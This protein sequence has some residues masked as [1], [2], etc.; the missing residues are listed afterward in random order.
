MSVMSEDLKTRIEARISY[1]MS[2]LQDLPEEYSQT[3]YDRMKWIQA[4]IA[5]IHDIKAKFLQEPR[6]LS[7]EQK[8]FAEMLYWWPCAGDF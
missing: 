4:T 1:W 7:P 8:M 6:P 2:E 5:G 3:N